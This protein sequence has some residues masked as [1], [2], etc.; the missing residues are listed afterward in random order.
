MGLQSGDAPE[1]WNIDH[2]DKV[3]AHYRSFIDAGSDIILTNTFGGTRFRLKLHKAQHRVA[4]LNTAAAE[5]LKKEIKTIN[6]RTEETL[7]IIIEHFKEME[8]RMEALED[9]LETLEDGK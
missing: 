2:P 9:K 6:R 7:G 8:D 5:I 3:A 1:F 4:E